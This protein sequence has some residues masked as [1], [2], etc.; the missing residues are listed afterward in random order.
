MHPTVDVGVHLTLTSEWP[1]YRWRPLSTRDPASGL[2]D[3]DGYFYPNLACLRAQADSDAVASEMRLQLDRARQAGLDPT[4]IDCHMYV[5]LEAKF[6]S[7]YIGLSEEQG[8]PA[9]IVGRGPNAWQGRD[10]LI[11]QWEERGYP[12]FDTLFVMGSNGCPT[13]R[14]AQAKQIFEQMPPGLTCLLLHPARDTPELRAITPDW[15]YRVADYTAFLTAELRDYVRRA[16]IQVI[17]YRAL[18]DLI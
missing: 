7:H 16:G 13:E 11:S 18:R 9:L 1:A 15:P 17:G 8:L 5:G 10:L 4:H 3:R 6:I 12:V 2:L 14:V